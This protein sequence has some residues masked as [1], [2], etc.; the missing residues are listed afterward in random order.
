MVKIKNYLVKIKDLIICLLK[1]I[2]DLI[3]KLFNKIKSLEIPHKIVFGLKKLFSIIKNG[4]LRLNELR[5]P[6]VEKELK[7]ASI[8]ISKIEKNIDNEINL[9][10]LKIY[11]GD[12]SKSL[13]GLDKIKEQ[14]SKEE[15]RQIEEKKKELLKVEERVIKN[16]LELQEVDIE[17][18]S[19]IKK[20]S[21]GIKETNSKVLDKIKKVL[22][23][24]VLLFKKAF[25]A[26]IVVIGKTKNKFSSG[27]KIKER[28]KQEDKDIKMTI[29]YMNKMIDNSYKDIIKIKESY[30]DTKYEELL[31]LKEKIIDLKD[32]YTRLLKSDRFKE[33]KNDKNVNSIDSNHLL[34]HDNSIDNLISYVS[35][36]IEDVKNSSST[37]KVETVKP[38]IEEF[39]FDKN[40]FNLVKD[41]IVKDIK[42]SKEEVEK[43]KI[44]INGL[45]GKNKKAT[46]LS[47]L[48][49]F[50]RFSINTAISLIP[51]GIFKSKLI[52]TITSGII[53]NNRVKSMNSIIKGEEATFIDYESILETIK[54]KKSCL[55]NTN[56]V[57]LDT[58][59]EINDLNSRLVNDYPNDLEAIKLIRNLEEMKNDLQDEKD[60][61]ESLLKNMNKVKSKVKKKVA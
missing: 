4:I 42:L 37:K 35:K 38:K 23:K 39:K 12:I 5:K 16:I 14:A 19:K 57:L 24:I 51:F 17:S 3:I 27:K 44:E 58:I 43:I 13:K 34:Y 40:E 29:K 7:K 41:S 10:V 33:L 15:I 30:S 28:K 2:K 50:F 21:S 6:T 22:S 61:I 8:R 9:I 31:F 59:N 25:V 48:S 53:L 52:A 32:E 47:K 56:Y 60:K 45:K 1:K 18:S 26:V 55:K 46:V 36:V 20:I 49:N 11:R 54:D